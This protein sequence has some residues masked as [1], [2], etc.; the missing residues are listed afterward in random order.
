M[1]FVLVLHFNAK[2]TTGWAY[3]RI[4]KRWV[5]AVTHKFVSHETVL[6]DLRN[7]AAWERR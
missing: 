2:R 1:R 3:A 5:C 4:N 6:S 7:S